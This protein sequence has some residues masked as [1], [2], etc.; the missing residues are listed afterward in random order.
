VIA[1]EKKAMKEHQYIGIP[2]K[3]LSGKIDVEGDFVPTIN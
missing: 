2:E 1:K 3:L